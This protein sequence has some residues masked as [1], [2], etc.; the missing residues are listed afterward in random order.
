MERLDDVINSARSAWESQYTVGDP[1]WRLK[2]LYG[3]F[4]MIKENRDA[5]VVALASGRWLSVP[6]KIDQTKADTSQ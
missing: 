1:L 5:L 3:L 6:N 2:Q 4:Q